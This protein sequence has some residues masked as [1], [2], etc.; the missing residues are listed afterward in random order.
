MP[1][2]FSFVSSFFICT[3]A[4]TQIAP[5]RTQWDGWRQDI[6]SRRGTGGGKVL[7]ERT[8]VW[9]PGLGQVLPGR[10]DN[11]NN[12]LVSTKLQGAS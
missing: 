9:A 5:A 12:A 3:S 2:Q 11:K 6:R 8:R 1:R 4:P 7:F 10:I